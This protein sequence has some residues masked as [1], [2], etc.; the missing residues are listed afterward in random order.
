MGFRKEK[1]DENSEATVAFSVTVVVVGRAQNA[2]C[3]QRATGKALLATRSSTKSVV[4]VVQRIPSHSN[5]GL[6]IAVFAGMVLRVGLLSA[7]LK[8]CFVACVNQVFIIVQFD[9]LHRCDHLT[10][11]FCRTH[12]VNLIRMAFWKCW[13]SL[14]A[15]VFFFLGGTWM[16]SCVPLFNFFVFFMFRVDHCLFLFNLG[17]TIVLSS[18]VPV[19]RSSLFCLFDDASQTTA[20][21]YICTLHY[22]LAALVQH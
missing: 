12:T 9:S 16:T 18:T 3:R 20:N 13:E 8:Q 6:N 11:L 2:W 7:C 4:A 10:I 19:E 1:I 14:N 22:S 15:Q 5:L 17:S 21:F